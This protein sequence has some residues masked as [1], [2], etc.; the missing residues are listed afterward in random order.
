[1]ADNVRDNC[2]NPEDFPPEAALGPA[3]QP[4]SPLVAE[5]SAELPHGSPPTPLVLPEGP[6]SGEGAAGA[7]RS[8][9]RR[10][11]DRDGLLY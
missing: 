8:R 1:M 2:P 6:Y 3:Q 9:T 5:D 10:A 7:Q 11:A 4:V